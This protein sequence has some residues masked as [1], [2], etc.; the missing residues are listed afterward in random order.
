MEPF[1]VMPI[2]GQLLPNAC[3]DE[4]EIY[5]CQMSEA[6]NAQ[7]LILRRMFSTET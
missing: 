5:A 1:S 6:V 4:G 7:D 3:E 2:P